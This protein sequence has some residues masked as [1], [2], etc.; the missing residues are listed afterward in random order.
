VSCL[1]NE[2]HCLQGDETCGR[3]E[4]LGRPHQRGKTMPGP[5]PRQRTCRALR[6]I[7]LRSAWTSCF[8]PCFASIVHLIRCFVKDEEPSV[9]RLI[10]TLLIGV[11]VFAEHGVDPRDEV[12]G[13]LWREME[14]EAREIGECAWT[15]FGQFFPYRVEWCEGTV[16]ACILQRR[17]Q[18]PGSPRRAVGLLQ[19]TADACAD[20][21]GFE[22]P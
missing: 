6:I 4:K 21:S 7:T 10:G 11:H 1:V 9:C 3:A 16:R 17:V 20:V 8:V 2:I 18:V 14:Y 5:M 12:L 22:E 19:C 13:V 15:C